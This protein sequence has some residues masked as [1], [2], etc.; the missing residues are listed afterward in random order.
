MALGKLAKP[1]GGNNKR[2]VIHRARVDLNVRILIKPQQ[3]S[4][5]QWTLAINIPQMVPVEFGARSHCVWPVRHWAELIN[6]WTPG[7]FGSPM[8]VA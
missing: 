7:E 6:T 5:M 1:Q 4:S 2:P 3:R 8:C